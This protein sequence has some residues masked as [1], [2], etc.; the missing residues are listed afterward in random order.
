MSTLVKA[1][2]L[3]AIAHGDRTHVLKTWTSHAGARSYLV[4]AGSKRGASVAALQPLSRIELVAEERADRDLPIAREMRIDEPY[5]RLLADPL[6][7]TVALFVQELLYRVL[8]AESDDPELDLA[9]RK[10]LQALDSAEQL[11]WFPHLLLVSLSGPL[12]FRP[13]APL[14]GQDHFDLQEGCFT[15]AGARHGHLVA[16]PFSTALA[17]LLEHE[18]GEDPPIRIPASQRRQLLD[19]LLLYY[20]IHLEGMGEL[21]SPDVLHAALS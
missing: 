2:V 15:Q 3:R 21:R 17:R 14:P 4:R 6:R 16:P 9:V 19:Q 11:R 12:G 10:G 13:E 8:R 20:R 7:A 18:P 1:I 5:Q